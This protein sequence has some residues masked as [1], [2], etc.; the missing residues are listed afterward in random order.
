MANEQHNR[1]HAIRNEEEQNKYARNLLFPF[2]A[3]LWADG[4]SSIFAEDAYTVV[5]CV[6]HSFTKI[7][8]V[9]RV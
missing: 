5:E 2:V 4:N 8:Y 3:E 9:H 6:R 7:H 1:Q